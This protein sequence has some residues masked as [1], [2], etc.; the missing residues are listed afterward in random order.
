MVEVMIV[1][2]VSLALFTSMSYLFSG[3]IQASRFNTAVQ[4]FDSDIRRVASEVTTG[5]YPDFVGF[6]CSENITGGYGLSFSSGATTD[7]Q[8]TRDKCMFLGK[9]IAMGGE[10]FHIF[11]IAGKRTDTSGLVV[12]SLNEAEPTVVYGSGVDFTDR[13]STKYG[14]NIDSVCII[15]DS[16]CTPSPGFGFLLS[17]RGTNDL[18]TLTGDTVTDSSVELWAIDGSPISFDQPTEAADAITSSF[19]TGD[20]DA[21]R[22]PSGGV[23]ICIESGTTSQWAVITVG[24]GNRTLSTDLQIENSRPSAC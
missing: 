20:Y 5:F 17:I 24:G 10:D 18:G 13:R 8:G 11:S 22:N 2:G 4:E 19:E 3:R 7:A 21:M 9:V 6:D 1:L 14:L 16:G 15:T 12:S 23:R